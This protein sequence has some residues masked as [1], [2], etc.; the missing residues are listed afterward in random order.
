MKKFWLEYSEIKNA[1]FSDERLIK[2]KGEN[3]EELEFL[4]L[5]KDID[6]TTKCIQVM[7]RF[8]EKENVAQVRIPL[9]DNDATIMKLPRD[10]VKVA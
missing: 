3:N 9:V 6:E 4:V 2:L 10:M 1:S 5:A 8:L 7:V